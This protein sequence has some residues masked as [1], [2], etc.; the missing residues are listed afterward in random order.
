MGGMWWLYLTQRFHEQIDY[1]VMGWQS[2]TSQD[3]RT[4]ARL[5]LEDE[6]RE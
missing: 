3:A 6:A 2:S 4:L 5:L 1:Q